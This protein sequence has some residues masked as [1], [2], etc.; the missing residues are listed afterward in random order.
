[1][2]GVINFILG[3]EK[4]TENMNIQASAMV[5]DVNDIQ[6]KINVVNVQNPTDY[7]QK[8]GQ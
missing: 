8:Y 4:T 2:F 3:V 6:A 5:S 7:L 1:M